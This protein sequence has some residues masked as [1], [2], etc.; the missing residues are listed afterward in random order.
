MARMLGRWRT[1]GCGCKAS[2]P[3]CAGHQG[4]SRRRK[5]A[6]QRAVRREAA[7]F[8]EEDE[9]VEK[10]WAAFERGEKGVTDAP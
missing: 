2:G 6:E 9:P 4:D 3:D 5:R 8:F 10:M 1:G 7:E